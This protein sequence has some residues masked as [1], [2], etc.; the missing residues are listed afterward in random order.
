MKEEYL[1]KISEFR[2]KYEYKIVLILGLILVSVV[3]FEAGYLMNENGSGDPLI[4]DNSLAEGNCQIKEQAESSV[5][6]ALAEQIVPEKKCLYV[7][8]KNSKIYH[9]PGCS[10]AKR[11]K[12]ENLV[13]F[14]SKEEALQ[15]GRQPDKSCI[16]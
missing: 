3:S 14:A 15:G 7:A 12:P 9:T 16:K 8:S 10:F 4:I 13:C 1:K 11:I 5:F 2:I 6:P